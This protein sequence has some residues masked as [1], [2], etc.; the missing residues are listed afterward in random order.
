MWDE[1]LVR[2]KNDLTEIIMTMKQMLVNPLMMI[3]N[4]L[5][6]VITFQEKD[7]IRKT[8]QT[9]EEDRMKKDYQMPNEFVQGEAITVCSFSNLYHKSNPL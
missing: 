9:A 3:L 1:K 6:I 5:W 4:C 7:Y 2:L 8:R